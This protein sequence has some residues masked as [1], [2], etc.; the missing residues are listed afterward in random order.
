[1]NHIGDDYTAIDCTEYFEWDRM[2][3]KFI[4]CD[5]KSV[6]YVFGTSAKGTA[7]DTQEWYDSV[8]WIYYSS[9]FSW[10]PS[11]RTLHVA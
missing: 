4:V 10:Y 5:L 1:M 2:W 6:H 8:V 3:C 7:N 11:L 9:Q